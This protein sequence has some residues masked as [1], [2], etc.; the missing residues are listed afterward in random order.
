MASLTGIGT[1][2]IYKIA[3]TWGTAVS[4]GAGNKLRAEITPNFNVE[5]LLFRQ[6][7][8]G[9]YMKDS[10]TRGNLK[11]T[12]GI[13]MDG[14]YRN[15]MDNIIAQLMGTAGA[16]TEQTG[17]QAD[18][19]HTITF[20]TSLNAKYGT[21]AYDS[22]SAT[23]HEYATTAT[24]SFT[25]S[26]DDAPGVLDFQAELLA[27]NIAI[28]G[29]TNTNGSMASATITDTE[30]VA[31]GFDDYFR[32]NTS[33]GASLSSGDNLAITSFSLN[34]VREQDIKGEIKG[35]AGNG[36]PVAGAGLTGTLS[37]TLKELTDHTY[38]TIWNA[39][40]TQKCTL[41]IQG[42]Q[43]GSGT[44]KTFAFYIPKMQLIK[45]PQYALTSEGTNPVT[46][47]FKILK[48]ASNP[49]GMSSTYPYFEITNGLSTS[50][51][52]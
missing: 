4:G 33:S 16:P 14:G 37:I 24:R 1:N 36:S 42:S 39:E 46:L 11:P 21:L 15:C 19:K 23:V 17:G 2:A 38:Y 5:E 43:I 7:G 13:S 27:N 6:V 20:N 41:N 8:S 28:T 18:Y 12:I 22:S 47:E 48:A 30:M 26:G 32:I 10:A 29:A 25:I 49:S 40:T 31:F 35:S 52:A 45:E 9:L 44:N 34:L 51:L 50:L 3:S